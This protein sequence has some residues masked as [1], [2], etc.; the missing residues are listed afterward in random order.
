MIEVAH[1]FGNGWI[2]LYSFVDTH[3]QLHNYILI[4]PWHL[5]DDGWYSLL[6]FLWYR[7]IYGNCGDVLYRLS[8]NILKSCYWITKKLI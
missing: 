7:N 3:I 6:P 4:E 2:E 5:N 1:I 8:P